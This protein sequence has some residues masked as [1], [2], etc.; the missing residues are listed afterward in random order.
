MAKDLNYRI[1]RRT[2]HTEQVYS[3]NSGGF[4]KTINRKINSMSGTK[5]TFITM[6]L[7]GAITF[8]LFFAPETASRAING[9]AGLTNLGES[10]KDVL[11]PVC[12]TESFFPKLPE[13]DGMTNALLIGLDTRE[14]GSGSGLMNTDT[15]M[16]ASLDHKT[17]KV[18]LISFPRDLYVP[19]KINGKGP[20]YQKINAVYA[21]GETSK[22][23]NGMELLKT[24][25]EDWLDIEIHYT[26]EVNFSTVI[27]IVDALGGVT[28]DVEKDYTD[29]YP[30][31]EL[32]AD[33]Q[34]DCKRATD[35]PLY[36]VFEFDAGEHELSGE[37]ALIYARMRQYSSDFDRARRQQQV[38]DAIKDKFL[39]GDMSLIE[40]AKFGWDTYKAISDKDNVKSNIDYNVLLAGM[41]LLDKVDHNPIQIVLDPSFGG[42]G[43][44]VP[45]SIDEIYV[46]K[47]KGNNFD[48]VRKYIDNLKKNPD[49]YKE[50]AN[51]LLANASGLTATKSLELTKEKLPFQF[52]N[53]ISK[54]KSQESGTII[55]VFDDE[56]TE[57]INFLKKYYNTTKVRFSP[58]D[59][60]VKQ[61]GYG[62]DILVV[63][64]PQES[65]P[66]I[67]DEE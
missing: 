66:S 13:T 37:D 20:Y 25:M 46:V 10:C 24:N 41:R 6:L 3:S 1:G 62:E 32:P 39:E 52:L 60:S 11:N 65:I 47:I 67:E 23:K 17:G 33:M 8:L 40:K 38:V 9:V 2:R 22:A 42:G 28:V 53:Y 50:Q 64:G 12:W 51:V 44:F 54:P 29:V 15:M 57:T 58:E 59:W 18:Y 61:S 4:F 55:Y 36:C 19:Y 48:L 27:D 5:F 34:K 26:A 35:L 14:A 63:E 56:K 16:L 21:A 31:K 7:V 45:D 49:L 43:Y 30:Y